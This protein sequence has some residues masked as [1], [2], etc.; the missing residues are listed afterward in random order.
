VENGKLY[1]KNN[2]QI[3]PLFNQWYAWPLLIAPAPAAMNIANAHLK[4]MKSYVMA[5]HIHAAANKNPA[6]RGGP[7]IDYDGKR[8][9]EIKGL[10]DRTIKEQAD[11]IH[12]AESIIKLNELLVNEAKGYSMEPL[13]QSIPD[14]LKGYV[15]LIYDLNNYPAVRFIEGLLYESKYYDSSLQS[16]ALSEV[17]Q[18]ERS[19]VFSTPRLED[20]HHLHLRIPF[21]HEGIDELFSM[22]SVPQHFGHIKEVLRFGSEHDEMFYSFLSTERP[23]QSPPYEGDQV[24]VRYFGHACIL[25]ETKNVSIMTDPLISYSHD[26]ELFRYTYSNLPETID[27]AL[28]THSHADHL[29]FESLLQLR[30]KIKNIVVPKNGGG[31]LQD[32]SLKLMLRNVGFKNVIEIDEMETIEVDG[33]VI[34]SVPFL[35]EHADLNIRTKSAHVITLLGKSAMCAADSANIEP[36]LYDHVHKSLG[37]IDV[38]FLGMECDGA[39]LTWVYG[40][41]LTKP[42]D[43]K[44]DQSRKLSGSDC[45]RG[46]GIVEKLNC[47]QVYV[48]AMGAE[49]WLDFVTSLKY[50]ESSKQIVESNKLI[51]R[52]RERGLVSERLYGSKEIFL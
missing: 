48:Y 3:E 18:D 19:F 13:Y 21:N 40:S 30:H 41:L 17:T 26:S 37:D 51:D 23:P 29:M 5:P 8:V 25:M 22:R 20:Q 36:R 34:T 38:L 16:I 43:R 35:G 15:E 2:I 42:V 28:I 1:L 44:M 32:P 24:R 39:P 12:F 14:E 47:K 45:D 46:I 7:F 6:M 33:G 31:F 10:M 50:D 27:Y 11:K 9:D 49:P 4:I 52:C